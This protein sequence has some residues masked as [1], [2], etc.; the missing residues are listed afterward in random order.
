MKEKI[1]TLLKSYDKL[2]FTKGK[3]KSSEVCIYPKEPKHSTEQ[4]YKGVMAT[5]RKQGFTLY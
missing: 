2:S 5:I 4:G 1:E 3:W